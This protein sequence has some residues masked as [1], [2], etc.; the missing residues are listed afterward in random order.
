MFVWGEAG[1]SEVQK[2][3]STVPRPLNIPS[4]AGMSQDPLNAVANV[5]RT[6]VL[7]AGEQA[8]CLAYF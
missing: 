5:G 1:R 3:D 8:T 6:G 4:D 2:V 7:T